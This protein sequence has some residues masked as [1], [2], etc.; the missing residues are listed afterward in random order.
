V[1][2]GRAPLSADHTVHLTRI[3]MWADTLSG[4]QLRGWS[5]TWFLGTP[6]G[7]LYPVLGDM[8]VVGV[9]V[10]SLGLLDWHQSYAIGLTLAFVIPAWAMLR[11][12]RSL[13]L[14]PVPGLV[15]GALLLVDA[16]AYRE[17]GWMYTMTF[18]V[19]PQH[20]STGL[21]WLGLSEL[22]IACTTE[23]DARVRRHIGAAALALGAS[24][25]AHPMA[26]L[27]IAIGGPLLVLVVGPR[28]LSN[29]RRTI[30]TALVGGALGVA[31]A[32]WWVLPM[33]QHRAWM[34]SYGWMWQ[35]LRWMA[36][37]AA[38]GRWAQHMPTAVG[39]TIALGLL[40]LAVAGGRRGRFFGAY[41]LVLWLFAARDVLWWFRLDQLSEGFTHL[42]YQRFI[43]AAKPGLWLAAGFAV[44]GAAHLARLAWTR[45]WPKPSIAGPLAAAL[46]VAAAG[47]TGWMAI[48]TRQTMQEHHVGQVQLTRAPEPG[49]LDVAYPEVAQWLAER[50]AQREPGEFWRVTVVAPRNTHWFM[51][52]PVLS[53]VPVYKQGFT[54][55]DNFVHKPESARVEV[56][57]AALVRYVIAP[58][59]RGGRGGV[60]ADFG[61][62]R[63]I[64]RPDAGQRPLAWLDGDG[65][66]EVLEVADDGTPTRIRVTGT[67][68]R[69]RLTLAVS[70][71]PRW[72]VALDGVPLEGYEVPIFGDGAIATAADRRGTELR[73]GKAEG[74]DGTEPTLLAVDVSDGE[75]TISYRP[76]GVRD[77]VAGLV[78][79]LAMA[80]SI[81][82]IAP[83]GRDG[84]VG[85]RVTAAMKRL[86][87][88]GHPAV[89][90][91]LLAL[92]SVWAWSHYAAARHEEDTRAVGR[93]LRGP[94]RVDGA[95]AGMFKAGMLIRP[96]VVVDRRRGGPAQIELP[97][98]RLG[99]ALTGWLAIDDDAA[100]VRR[101]GSH[102]VRIEASTPEGVIVLQPDRPVPHQAGLRPIAIDTSQWSGQ[103]VDLR[104]VVTSEGKSPPPL[105]FDLQLEAASP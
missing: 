37:E 16:G 18:G 94:V 14:G 19:W 68:G 47:L 2:L 71:Y 69:T 43:T 23:D 100:K 13:G 65:T 75:V 76:R 88:L 39:T 61:D 83:R 41:A 51:D 62:L 99:D 85:P 9:R 33:L 66:V 52:L 95:S 79:L 20:L 98:V 17:G 4:G 55:G 73:G 50:W 26:M 67:D 48:G 64:E 77:V 28:P 44:G 96:A 31:V 30:P 11:V 29:L 35:P 70:G 90:L 63:I 5:P 27:G 72:H 54:P 74:D 6:V 89:P 32:A 25:L 36:Q 91:G 93:L 59:R 80:L 46:G 103:T 34:A 57:D 101:N 3:W 105:G 60:V 21:T 24:L 102:R 81:A 12:G 40:A 92:C 82:L 10:A 7:E 8:L 104:V 78:S 86:R 42:Q 38:E 84:G 22:A 87:P 1:P 49:P 58:P 53:G 97:Q 15:A 45:R 56:L